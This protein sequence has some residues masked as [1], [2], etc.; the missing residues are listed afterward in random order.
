MIVLDSITELQPRHAG[1]VVVSGSHGGVI[2]AYYAARAGVR[3]ALFNDAGI[4]RDEA[5]IGGL[6]YLDPL[7]VAAAAVDHRS[8][9]I[10]DGADTLACGI[11]TRVN[12]L[13]AA[14]G[15]VAGMQAVEAAERLRTAPGR[16]TPPA[17]RVESRAVFADDGLQVCA[18]DS[19]V[20]ARP[21]DAGAVLACGSH[22]GLHGHRPDTVLGVAARVAIFNDAGIGKDGAGTSRLPVLE[23]R[24]IAAATVTAASARIGSARST[25][26]DGI[27]SAVN[28]AAAALG[29]RAGF[30]ARELRFL[31]KHKHRS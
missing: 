19:V 9:R 10:G 29:L 15:V 16:V 23:A 26:F 3:A 13:G 4:G 12:A 2:A 21:E 8:A 14:C 5:G 20:L 6:A 31:I 25:W 11:V 27:V 18:I 17:P 24:G 1:E 30:A 7:G 28:P 22:G